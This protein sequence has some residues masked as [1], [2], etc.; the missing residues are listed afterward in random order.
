MTEP[1]IALK[2]LGSFLEVSARARVNRH[3]PEIVVYVI[4]SG[5]YYYVST[6]RTGVGGLVSRH[7][8]LAKAK[9]VALAMVESAYREGVREARKRVHLYG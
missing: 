1:H 2:R 8:T 7:R 9:G 4:D 5:R 3:V 6:T